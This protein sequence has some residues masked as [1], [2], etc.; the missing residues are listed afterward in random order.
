[1]S[2]QGSP[3]LELDVRRRR[4][5]PRVAWLALVVAPLTSLSM[6]PQPAATICAALTPLLVALG[7][8]RT[9]W[10][11]QRER[12]QRIVWSSQGRWLLEDG[13][14]RSC[15][16]VLR[17]DTRVGGG[18]VWLRWNANRTRSMLLVSGDMDDDELRR[19]RMRLRLEGVRTLHPDGVAADI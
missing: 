19:L 6:L 9:G 10:I 11:G 16:G 17:A 2:L 18:F 5:E 3:R 4:W 7:L 13:Q 15:E 14:G 12:I 1:M 8:W